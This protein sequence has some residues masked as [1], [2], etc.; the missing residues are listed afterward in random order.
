MLG[1]GYGCG[2]KLRHPSPSMSLF[3]PLTPGSGGS[4]GLG[5]RVRIRVSKAVDLYIG[6][7]SGKA[8]APKPG[9]KLNPNPNLNPNLNPRGGIVP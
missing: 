3:T 4:V 5:D 1:R 6:F 2:R 9:V 7:Q 8:A